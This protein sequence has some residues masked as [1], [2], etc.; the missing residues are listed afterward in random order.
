[1]SFY[2]WKTGELSP[3]SPLCLGWRNSGL[4]SDWLARLNWVVLYMQSSTFKQKDSPLR[5]DAIRETAIPLIISWVFW[6][7]LTSYLITSS[8]CYIGDFSTLEIPGELFNKDQQ[9]VASWKILYY[10]GCRGDIEYK[11]CILHLISLCQL[12]RWQ[13]CEKCMWFFP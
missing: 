2:L 11:V 4:K 3:V 5:R 13:E 9:Q 1:M 10:A 7:C 6:K 12:V 8:N